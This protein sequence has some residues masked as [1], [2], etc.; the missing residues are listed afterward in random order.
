M[1][2]ALGSNSLLTNCKSGIFTVDVEGK[3][4]IDLQRFSAKIGPVEYDARINY[5]LP[6]LVEAFNSHAQLPQL[7]VQQARPIASLAVPPTIEHDWLW[8]VSLGP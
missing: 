2:P 1:R 5:V 3:T 4:V 7:Q 6:K 8:N